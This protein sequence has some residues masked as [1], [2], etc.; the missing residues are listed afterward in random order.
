MAEWILDN[1]KLMVITEEHVYRRDVEF[2]SG[3]NMKPK[4]GSIRIINYDM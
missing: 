2:V 1:S 3:T 4:R